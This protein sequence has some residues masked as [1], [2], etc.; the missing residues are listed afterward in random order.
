MKKSKYIPENVR[1]DFT[2]RSR[3]YERQSL[4]LSLAVDSYIIFNLL[5]NKKRWWKMTSNLRLNMKKM[6]LFFVIS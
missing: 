2:Y 3:S 6:F 4:M 1:A 5:C